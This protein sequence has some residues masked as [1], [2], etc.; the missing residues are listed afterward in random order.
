MGKPSVPLVLLAGFAGPRGTARRCGD[1]CGVEGRRSV[2]AAMAAMARLVP[3]ICK[4]V[5]WEGI[6]G[7]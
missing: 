3:K 7:T 1:S 4:V 6:I 2:A 5:H